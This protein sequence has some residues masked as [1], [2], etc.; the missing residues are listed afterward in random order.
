M[1][2]SGAQGLAADVK[3]YG[4]WMRNEANPRIGHLAK[5][6]PQSWRGAPLRNTGDVAC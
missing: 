5:A 2:W 4:E 1:T 6:C 3:A